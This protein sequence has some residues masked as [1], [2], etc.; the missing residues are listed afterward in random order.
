MIKI[1]KNSII[2]KETLIKWFNPYVKEWIKNN[3]DDFTLPQKLGI[4]LIKKNKNVLITA[5][6]GSGKTLAAFLWILNRLIEKVEKNELE[7]RVYCIYVSPLRALNNDIHRNLLEPLNEV[8]EI[9][10]SSGTNLEN[11]IR[12][13]VRTGDTPQHEKQKQLKKPP[14]ILI[15]TPETLAIILVAPKFR[16]K[17]RG[18]ECV[19]VDEIHELA[20]SKRGIHLTLSLERLEK[21][22][23]KKIQRIGLSATV[24]PLKEV[25]KF[26][27]GYEG[28]KPRECYI[29]DARFSKKFDLKVIAPVKD[30][31]Y[32]PADKINKEM[33]KTI[34]KLIQKHKTTLIFTNTRSATERVVFHL[35]SMFPEKYADLDIGAH[36]SS[37]SRDIRLDVEEKLKKGE[38]K[39]VVSSTSLELGIDIGYID[40]VI[41][42]GSPKSVSRLLQRVGRAGHRLHEVSKGR[43]ISMDRDDLVEVAV[44]V[45]KAYDYFV[46]KIHIPKNCLDV[47]AQHIMGMSLERKWKIEEAFETIRNAYPFHELKYEDFVKLLEY[48]S[49]EYH[50][51]HDY[52]VYGKIWLDKEK[53]YF[54]RRGRYARV[55]Y[56]LNIGTIPDEVKIKVKTLD[57]KKVGYIEEAFLER[58]MPGDIFV[59]GGKTYEFVKSK[60][61]IAYVKNAKGKKP[62]VPSWFSEKLPLS[63][64]LAIEIGKYRKMIF[65]L[66]ESKRSKSK[67]LEFIKKELLLSE[68]EARAILDYFIIEHRFLKKHGINN[69]PSNDTILIET[70]VDER[71][72]KNIVFHTLYGRKVND[73][74]SR[75]YAYVLSKIV[76]RSIGITVSD[77]GFV[78]MVPQISINSNKWSKIKDVRKKIY[79]DIV[80]VKELLKKVD[81]RNVEDILKKAVINTEMMKRKFRHVATRGLMILR[82]Y[83]G[84]EISVEKQQFSAERLLKV[85]KN[86]DDFPLLKEVFR[87]ILED[88]MDIFH[89]KEILKKIRNGK[90]KTVIADNVKVPSPF[91]HNLIALGYSDVVLMEDRKKLLVRLHEKV[92]KEIKSK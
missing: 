21:L 13:G 39:V 16:E 84:Y 76:G 4:P 40:L 19:I 83:K 48:L 80:D 74:L 11:K 32:T 82:N 5:P 10:K 70:F 42:I 57:G 69:F 60:R 86:I 22:S 27:V 25:A 59:L 54:G 58:L 78:L 3:F 55:I 26:L 87:E 88:Y 36:H 62:T 37:I 47:L 35:K 23:D 85:I 81:E 41:Q 51:L 24:S 64:D 68:K 12:I 2:K 7:D 9:A 89:A 61:S 46:D 71:G 15:T 18:V 31:L 65:E 52:K 92:L 8:I 29:V 49:G 75:A 91:A 38:L 63:F 90:I 20:S 73:A 17:L 53:G 34:D 66:I 45:R 67:I 1:V 30:L 44:M 14:H 50:T 43:I 77:N 33:Y 28:N 6:T 72:Y 79:E 56:S